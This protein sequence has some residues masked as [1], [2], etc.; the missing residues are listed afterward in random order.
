MLYRFIVVM[1]QYMV[2]YDM[3]KDGIIHIVFL[4][5]IIRISS[6]GDAQN[7]TPTPSL[8]HLLV[9]RSPLRN[10]RYYKDSPTL[11]YALFSQT[12][13]PSKPLE[14]VTTDGSSL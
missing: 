8:S 13:N 12:T 10:H 14:R 9:A 5:G 11:Q 3:V 1:V 2:W 6:H 7:L 4:G